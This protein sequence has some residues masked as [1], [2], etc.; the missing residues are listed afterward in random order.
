MI[1]DAT[2]RLTMRE[3]GWFFFPLLLN[4]QMMSISHSVINA[5]LARAA[6]AVTALA[7]AMRQAVETHGRPENVIGQLSNG[8]YVIIAD[9][10]FLPDIQ[11]EIA[12]RFERSAGPGRL[13]I[14]SAPLALRYV[15]AR[16]LI[17]GSLLVIADTLARTL[18]AP[19]QLP[20]GVLTALLGVPLF[21][22]L[23]RREQIR[24]AAP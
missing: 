24:T 12:S 22:Y 7:D 23:L 15:S 16:K 14:A 2:P 10:T 4:V 11:Q 13:T 5:A 19:T 6:E 17:S 1:P 18:V 9:H 3:V 20:V 8:E 21:L